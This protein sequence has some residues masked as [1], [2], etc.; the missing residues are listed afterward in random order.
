MSDDDD[1]DHWPTWHVYT[2]GTLLCATQHVGSWF[3]GLLQKRASSF[4]PFF[5]FHYV[6]AWSRNTV[7]RT[8]RR[9]CCV[10]PKKESTAGAPTENVDDV[11]V[12]AQNSGF[13]ISLKSEPV[14]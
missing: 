2:L 10:G 8:G 11:H 12:S 4:L 7:R 14:G 13:I 5:S 1:D 9:S 3:S 6:H